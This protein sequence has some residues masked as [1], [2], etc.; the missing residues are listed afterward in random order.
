MLFL[1]I[2]IGLAEPVCWLTHSLTLVVGAGK[3]HVLFWT[4]MELPS[5]DALTNMQAKH[6]YNTNKSLILNKMEQK[7]HGKWTAIHLPFHF[8]KWNKQTKKNQ[9][10]GF[11]CHSCV[12]GL[13]EQRSEEAVNKK[14]LL[15]ENRHFYYV[16]HKNN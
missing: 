2:W 6:P 9:N 5:P 12:N 3:F 11:S 1:R 4:P 7:P 13:R 15:I 16:C 8:R 14:F 10:Q